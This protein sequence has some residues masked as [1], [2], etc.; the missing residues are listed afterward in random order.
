MEAITPLFGL[1]AQ[2]YNALVTVSQYMIYVNPAANPIIYG[3]MHQNFRRAFRLT[4]PCI[5]TRKVR[6]DIS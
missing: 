2:Y 5:F 6:T 1:P 3:L 4:F